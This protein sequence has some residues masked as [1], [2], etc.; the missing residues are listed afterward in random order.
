SVR[1]RDDGAARTPSEQH[2]LVS[3]FLG[4]AIGGDRARPL[5]ALAAIAARHDADLPPPLLQLVGQPDDERRLAGAA[6]A[7]VADNKNGNSCLDC[8]TPASLIRRAPQAREATVDGR[9]GPQ[10]VAHRALAVPDVIQE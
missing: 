6:D 3:D 8:G 9:D 10:R 5:R 7:D 4:I 1:P 2:G